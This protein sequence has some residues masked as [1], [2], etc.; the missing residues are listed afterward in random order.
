M[1]FVLVHGWGFDASFWTPLVARLPEA[2]VTLTD[3]G[4]LSGVADEP[5]DWPA[6]A[7]AIGHSLGVLWLLKQGRG[8]FRGLISMQ[9]LDRYCPHVPEP[10]V[11]ALRRGLDR[12]PGGTLLAF[13]HSCGASDFADPAALNV[14]RLREGLDWLVHW[15]AEA[16]KKS[17]RCPVLTL[18]SQD[19]V[20]VPAAM[21]EAIWGKENIVWSPSGGH[22]LPMTRPHWCADHVIEFAHSVS[23]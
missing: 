7:I 14:P 21:S 18:A 10:R 20:I 23:P 8:R 9:G 15:D 17:L 1:H 2:D 13:W 22:A 5:A 12:D 4:F 3:L 11:A 6:D 19:D 16:A